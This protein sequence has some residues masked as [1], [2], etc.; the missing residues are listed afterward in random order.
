MLFIIFLYFFFFFI[1]KFRIVQNIISYTPRIMF[2][3]VFSVS[4]NGLSGNKIDVELDVSNGLPAFNIVGLPDAAIQES[5]ERVRSALKNSG[6]LFP[7]T[8]ITVNLAPADIRK[9]GPSFDLP[10]AIGILCREQDFL[11]EYMENSLFVGELALD[12]KLRSV[13][14]ILPSVIFAKEHG[15]KYMFLPTENLEEA[16]L[17]PGVHLVGVADLAS[18][19]DILSG[20]KPL[21]PHTPIDPKVYI[22]KC[23]SGVKITGF[24]HVIGQEH[25][26]RALTIAAAGGHNILME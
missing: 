6:F 10:I 15:I 20:S 12:G 19:I 8:R 4:V 9:K 25:A 5:K 7:S 1:R 18:L 2:S 22:E 3:K 24:E 11:E 26:K 23:K 13:N 14:A 17:I 21:P 16:S